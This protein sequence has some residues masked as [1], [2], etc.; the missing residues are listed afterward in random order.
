MKS[1]SVKFTL[2]IVLFV[3]SIVPGRTQESTR[4]PYRV[5]VPIVLGQV[6]WERAEI[7]LNWTPTWVPQCRVPDGMPLHGYKVTIL[8]CAGNLLGQGITDTQGQT[9]FLFASAPKITIRFE[10]TIEGSPPVGPIERVLSH[11]EEDLLINLY[12]Q[13]RYCKPDWSFISATWPT[14]TCG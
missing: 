3:L 10:G 14:G 4:L 11:A 7:T 9:S 1:V 8:D 6:Q 12:A 2:I 13:R 5:A